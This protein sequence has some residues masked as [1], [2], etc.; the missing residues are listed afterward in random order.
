ML[1]TGGILNW[2]SLCSV[3]MGSVIMCLP[4]LAYMH[5]W[6]LLVS[7]NCLHLSVYYT[8]TN[9]IK[10][11]ISKIKLS[12]QIILYQSKKIHIMFDLTNWF[13]KNA[14]FLTSVEKRLLKDFI[15]EKINPETAARLFTKNVNIKKQSNDLIFCILETIVSLAIISCNSSIQSKC[16]SLTSALRDLRK[17]LLKPGNKTL[18]CNILNEMA[19]IIGGY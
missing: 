2:A 17:L 1:L 11:F 6:Y 12:P 19:E 10:I 5:L 8:H 13:Q 14:Q 7:V 9:I 18:P 16:V 15:D 4:A 3:C